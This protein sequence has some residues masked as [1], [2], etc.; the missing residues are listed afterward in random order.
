MKNILS[1]LFILSLFTN[2]QAQKRKSYFPVW[3]FHQPNTTT[4]G[5]SIG[6]A[7]GMKN[8]ENTISNGIRIEIIGAGILIPAISVP[9]MRDD[10]ITEKINRINL[11]LTGTLANCQV[12]GISVGY[13]GESVYKVNGVSAT[14]C[15]NYIVISNGL[16]L[17][18]LLTDNDEMNGLQVGCINRSVATNGVQIGVLNFSKDLRGFQIGLW[19]K[20]GKRSLPIINWQFKKAEDVTL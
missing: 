15:L 8:T 7:S 12:N 9:M 5:I 18:V 13:V 3:T 1:L 17:A 19:N 11:S 14:G 10:N 2:L 6:I 20:N 4:N 16:Q